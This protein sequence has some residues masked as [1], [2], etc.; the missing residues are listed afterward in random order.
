MKKRL[1]GGQDRMMSKGWGEPS[2]IRGSWIWDSEKLE[3]IPEEKFYKK[4]EVHNVIQD[5]FKVPIQSMASPTGEVFESKSAYRAH[6]KANGFRESGGEHLKD[7]MRLEF[8]AMRN[9]EKLAEQ[10]RREVLEDTKK[11]AM[12]IK[13]DRISI[14]EQEKAIMQKEAEKWGKDYWLKNLE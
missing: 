9:K 2:G 6:L 3:M 1:D 4:V 12:D 11:V 14:T 10:R 13:Y 7:V 8:E 5:T